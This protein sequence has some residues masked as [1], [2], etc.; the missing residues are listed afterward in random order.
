MV[1]MMM[2][3]PQGSLQSRRNNMTM[4]RIM[5]E[6]EMTAKNP[7]IRLESIGFSMMTT[8]RFGGTT[9]AQRV[10]GGWARSIQSL[11]PTPVLLLMLDGTP[12]WT[13]AWMASCL[14]AP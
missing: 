2:Q 14:M 9:K 8:T 6:T 10:L 5:Q 12:L 11:S 3:T 1:V 7:R 4:A 13:R